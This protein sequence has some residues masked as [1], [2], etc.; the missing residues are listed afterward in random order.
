MKE[1]A[2]AQI[3]QRKPKGDKRTEKITGIKLNESLIR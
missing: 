3:A 2:E 1:T